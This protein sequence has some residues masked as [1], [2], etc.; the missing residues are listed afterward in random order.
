M[1]WT[2]RVHMPWNCSCSGFME[3]SF[4]SLCFCDRS[5]S[6]GYGCVLVTLSFCFLHIYLAILKTAPCQVAGG[7]RNPAREEG[8]SKCMWSEYL[9]VP[10]GGAETGSFNTESFDGQG[11]R[12]G[13][14]LCSLLHNIGDIGRE[15][16][17]RVADLWT[18]F[19]PFQIPWSHTWSEASFL[20]VLLICC[21][22]FRSYRLMKGILRRS[23]G[24]LHQSQR[25]AALYPNI[26]GSFHSDIKEIL[27]FHFCTHSPRIWGRVR[28]VACLTPLL[29]HLVLSN[30]GQNCSQ[31]TK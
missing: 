2:S 29:M 1:C 27:P 22:A 19:W 11:N 10:M 17:C 8:E 30:L 23:R 18:A 21:S 14:T 15:L 31:N 5:C 6:S 25:P 26:P 16:C 13:P 3:V 7:D 4:F 12:E 20:M 24:F 28:C 9:S